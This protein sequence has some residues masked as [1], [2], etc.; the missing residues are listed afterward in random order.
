MGGPMMGGP[1]P[2]PM[3]GPKPGPMGGPMGSP[4]VGPSG[5]PNAGPM[6]ASSGCPKG[7]PMGG[8]KSGGNKIPRP[9]AMATAQISAIANNANV[10]PHH[11]PLQ[12]YIQVGNSRIVVSSDFIPAPG[13]QVSTT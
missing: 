8:P 7:G 5:G 9:P 1:Q 2:G 12:K 11:D 10:L 6:G 13:T 4:Q 3:G